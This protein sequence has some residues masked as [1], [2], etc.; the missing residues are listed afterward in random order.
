MHKG[1]TQLL[2]ALHHTDFTVT[3]RILAL[4]GLNQ[5]SSNEI[6]NNVAY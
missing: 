1:S 6:V 3:L 4:E 5:A 2:V